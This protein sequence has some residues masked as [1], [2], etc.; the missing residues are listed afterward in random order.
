MILNEKRE[1]LRIL[2][3]N[4]RIDVSIYRSRFRRTNCGFITRR[5][6]LIKNRIR[7][8][9]RQLGPGSDPIKPN[10]KPQYH[11]FEEIAK[12]PLENGEYAL[13]TSSELQG[14]SLRYNIAFSWLLVDQ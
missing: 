6:N 12:S 7:A 3:I 13:L 2:R 5:S 4:K 1:L 11:P 9:T 10:G 8:C 14:Q